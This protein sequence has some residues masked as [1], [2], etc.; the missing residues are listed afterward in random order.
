MSAEPTSLLRPVPVPATPPR[1]QVREGRIQVLQVGPALTMHGG[2][3][4]VEQLICDYLSPYAAIRHVDSTHEG[5]WLSRGFLF[6]R[7][8]RTLW[9]VLDTAE[10]MLVH[11]HFASRGSTLRKMLLAQLVLH[12]RRPLILHAHGGGFD[13]FHRGLAPLLRDRVNRTMQQA[14]LVIALS[15]HW[16]D[17]YIRECELS[18][19]QVVVLANPVRVPAKIVDRARRSQVQFLHL[20]KLG[21]GKGSYD[22]VKAFRALPPELRSRARLVLAGNGEL[23]Q[24]K[25][26]A[27][28]EP[29]IEVRSW[30]DPVERD[31]LMNESDAFALPSYVEGVPMSLLEAMASGLPSITTPVGGIPDVFT[32]GAE[33]LMVE[34]G[35]VPRLTEAM[36]RLIR[37]EDFRLSAGRR[38]HERAR[39]HDVHAYARRLAEHYQRIAPVAEWRAES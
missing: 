28:G 21:R 20:G 5:S 9:R 19:S 13:K 4:A 15:S 39:A 16:R 31:R 7:A 12:A 1:A 37:D 26:S 24:I 25:S 36:S 23:E 3:S 10:P 2:V 34:P 14:D 29:N 33:G 18:P 35:D 22:L 30:I 32:H 11:I 27:D 38:A 17:F 8:A 6:A